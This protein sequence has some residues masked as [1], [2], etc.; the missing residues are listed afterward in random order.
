VLGLYGLRN[1]ATFAYGQMRAGNYDPTTGISQDISPVVLEYLRSEV[2]RHNFQ[3]P[4]ALVSYPMAYISLP[5]FRILQPFGGWSGYK[6]G[7]N[8]AGRAEKIFVVLQEALVLNGRAETIL[9]SLTSYDFDSWKHTKLDG[10][11]IYTQ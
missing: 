4:V 9:R 8:W 2:A 10:M 3:R 11:I 1:Y 6:A 7:T 5:R